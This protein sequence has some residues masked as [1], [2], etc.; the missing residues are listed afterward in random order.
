MII[1]RISSLAPNIEFQ[2]ASRS[3]HWF[4]Q[5]IVGLIVTAA[6]GVASTWLVSLAG[7]LIKLSP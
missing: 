1:R 7:V 4:W 5:L 3:L 6:L 2:K